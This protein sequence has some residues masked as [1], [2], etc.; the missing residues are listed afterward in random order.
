MTYLAAS[1]ERRS[2]DPDLDVV[3]EEMERIQEAEEAD[4]DESPAAD[5]IEPEE[6]DGE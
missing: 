1:E 5:E 3:R 4:T 2:R 6:S